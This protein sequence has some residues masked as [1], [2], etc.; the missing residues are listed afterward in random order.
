MYKFIFL[1]FFIVSTSGCS[2]SLPKQAFNSE[3]NA[4]INHITI[5]KPPKIKE[6]SVQ[7]LTHPGN[8]VGGIVGGLI[9]AADTAA[10]TG[11]YN[12]AIAGKVDWDKYVMQQIQSE[13]EQAGYRVSMVTLRKPKENKKVFAKRYPPISADAVLDFYYDVGHIAS[14]ATTNYVPTVKLNARLTNL[15]NQAVLYEQQFT[16][17]LATNQKDVNLPPTSREYPNIKV[18]IA[19]APESVEALKAGIQQIA[20][21]MAIDLAK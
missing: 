15:Q 19:N 17:G 7:M 8:A 5:V 21:R 20:K 18:L 1:L 3:A 16:A 2:S 12:S 11:R 13:L 6:V 4:G 10:K 9:V 14:G